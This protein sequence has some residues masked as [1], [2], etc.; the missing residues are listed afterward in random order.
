MNPRLWELLVWLKVPIAKRMFSPQSSKSALFWQV[1]WEKRHPWH[2]GSCISSPHSHLNVPNTFGDWEVDQ[3]S[4]VLQ[5]AVPD[6]GS[7]AAALLL[8]LPFICGSISAT[9]HSYGGRKNLTVHTQTS[10]SHKVQTR[11]NTGTNNSLKREVRHCSL[12]ASSV[13]KAKP[14]KSSRIRHRC[15]QQSL[16]RTQP[17]RRE[18][19]ALSSEN[20]TVQ[21]TLLPPTGQRG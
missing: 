15:K 7:Q 21:I 10:C 9:C 19:Q 14:G 12:T 6:Q 4:P 3:A 8:F 17:C 11:G 13:L 20:A 18:G 5:W 16:P 2:Q 1:N